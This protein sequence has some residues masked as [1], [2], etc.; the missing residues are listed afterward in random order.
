MPQSL[1]HRWVDSFVLSLRAG[2]RAMRCEPLLDGPV[3]ESWLFCAYVA[4]ALGRARR[5]DRGA[6]HRSRTGLAFCRQRGAVV[7]LGLGPLRAACERSRT[8]W[9]LAGL[10]F[11]RSG[12]TL[13]IQGTRPEEA[14]VFSPERVPE[15]SVVSPVGRVLSTLLEMARD[16]RGPPLPVGAQLSLLVPLNQGVSMSRDAN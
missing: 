15:A 1:A 2:Y 8:N 4:W 12:A 16:R 10:T 7:D 11:P 9:G 3:T 6:P 13:G 14:I 5:R